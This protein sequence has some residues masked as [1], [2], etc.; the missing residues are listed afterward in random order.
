MVGKF[1]FLK[2]VARSVELEALQHLTEAIKLKI[3]LS[4]HQTIT[5]LAATSNSV[6]GSISSK[7]N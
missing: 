5:R 2:Q 7:P 6:I 3:V 4:Y 1:T